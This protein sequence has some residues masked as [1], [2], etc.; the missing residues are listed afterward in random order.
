MTKVDIA[1]AEKNTREQQ[2]EPTIEQSTLMKKRQ[3]YAGRKFVEQAMSSYLSPPAE[4][5]VEHPVCRV[6]EIVQ[7]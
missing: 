2:R 5:G 4:S 1:E 7:V 6:R 3:L